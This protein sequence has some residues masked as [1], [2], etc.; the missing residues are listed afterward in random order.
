MKNTPKNKTY[1]LV[2]ILAVIV[3]LVFIAIIIGPQGFQDI[4]RN[5]MAAAGTVF[6]TEAANT[7]PSPMPENYP[8]LPRDYFENGNQTNALMVGGMILVL[9]ILLGVLISKRN[10]EK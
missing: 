2:Y 3:I 6:P 9:I 8:D 10:N 4:E 5:R 1:F 7:I